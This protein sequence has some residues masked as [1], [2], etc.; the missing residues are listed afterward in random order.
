MKTL[1]APQLFRVLS[2]SVSLCQVIASVTRLFDPSRP[3]PPLQSHSALSLPAILLTRSWRID[4]TETQTFFFGVKAAFSELQYWL[5][6]ISQNFTPLS[7]PTFVRGLFN[8]LRVG[9]HCPS[10]PP[11]VF[12]HLFLSYAQPLEDRKTLQS[13]PTAP[14]FRHPHNEPWGTFEDPHTL[15]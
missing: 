1:G 11:P 15:Q 10:L 13:T 2:V 7:Y 5:G 4:A 3:Q 9:I 14:P 12:T 8:L 6:T